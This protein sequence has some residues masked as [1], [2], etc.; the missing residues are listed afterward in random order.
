ML[1]RSFILTLVSA[2]F[3]SDALAQYYY[4]DILLSRQSAE[5]ISSY[6][7]QRIRTVVLQSF[8]ADGS[9]TEG[10]RGRQI[11]KSNYSQLITEVESPAAG[12][13]QLTSTFDAAGRLLRTSDTTDGAGSVT[14]YSYDAA[15][16]VLEIQNV[17][18]SAGGAK[19]REEHLWTYDTTGAPLQ[20]LR[21]KN[22]SDTTVVSFV[23]GSNGK[24]EEETSV[25]RGTN[26]PSVSYFYDNSGRL[27]DVAAYNAKARRLLPLYVFEYG[28][29]GEIKSMM[30]VPEGSDEYQ[31]WQYTYN[32]AGLKTRELCYDKRRQLLGR[33]EYK[34][35]K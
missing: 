10:F 19:M 25:R 33:I 23:I 34:Y 4:R 14:E 32:E 21:I 9:P 5:L 15:G 17:S 1:K 18:T 30:V 31:T 35:E 13:S 6:K 28:P 26:L 3:V 29:K 27:T 8:E 12:S 2:L 22:Q 11:V 16:R 24:V 7:A 20:M